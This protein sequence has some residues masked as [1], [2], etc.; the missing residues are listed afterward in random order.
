M[1]AISEDRVLFPLLRLQA[2]A[3]LYSLGVRRGSGCLR[4][5]GACAL[6]AL[7]ATMA[8]VYMWT[9]GSGMVAVGAEDAIPALAALVGSLAAVALVFVKAPGTVFGCRDYDLVAALPVSVRTVVLAR[10]AP[11]YGFGAA[12]SVLMSA[13]LYAAYF[14]AVPVSSVSVASAAVIS[15]LAPLAPSAVAVLVS[16]ALT[17]VAVRFRHAGAVQ[18]VL[19]A[20]LVVG[21]VAASFV[22]SRSLSGADEVAVLAA[23]GDAAGALT[24]AVSSAY[25]PAAWAGS[26]VVDG[27]TAGFI[28]FCMLSLVLPALVTAGLAA[29]YPTVNALA[30]S[31]PRSRC[32]QVKAATA[33]SPLRA[34]TIKELRRIGSMPFYAMNDCAGLLLMVMA[35]V[36]ASVFGVDALLTSGVVDGVRLDAQTVEAMRVQVDAALPWVFGFCGAMSL[37]AAPSVSLEARANWLMLTA[38]VRA[39]TLLASKLLANIVLGGVAVAASAVA[40]FVGGVAPLI[41]LQCAAC[42]M[43]MLVG[44]ASIALAIDASRPNF[45][46]TSPS[47]IIKRGLP[48]MVGSLG[49]VL[50][51]FG[52]GFLSVMAA[53]VF[54]AA[55]SVAINLAAPAACALAGLA[56]LRMVACRGLP[57]PGWD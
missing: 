35:A 19:S 9:L 8:A 48:V 32:G 33:M 29:C 3:F 6:V 56:A 18:L 12:L 54:G 25:P 5:A 11:L 38:P 55:A 50:V 16:L 4:V 26:A 46:W 36:A 51:S 1:M 10:T 43:G 42:A 49:G 22:F 27:S 28:A 7:L 44:F 41:V 34:L 52:F 20:L 39:G 17:S 13:P 37:T 40:L 31:G 2:G 30:A 45:S 23:A 47:E 14:S 57:G 15:L 21:V 53:G 24:R